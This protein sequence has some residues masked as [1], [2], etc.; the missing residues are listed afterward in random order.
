MKAFPGASLLKFATWFSESYST[1]PTGD[2]VSE[3]GHCKINYI[4]TELFENKNCAAAEIV[5]D[6]VNLNKRILLHH[7]MNSDFVFAFILW[8]FL[9]MAVAKAFSVNV[10]AVD[11][12]ITDYYLSTHRS[13]KNYIAGWIVLGRYEPTVE[14]KERYEKIEKQIITHNLKTHKYE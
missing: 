9:K 5:N 7:M 1:L 3:D 12:T 2:Y 14:N 11:A 4:E 6:V 8:V 13:K 10:Y